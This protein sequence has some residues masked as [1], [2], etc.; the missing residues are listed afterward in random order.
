MQVDGRVGTVEYFRRKPLSG[1]DREDDVRI[2]RD[3]RELTERV[4]SGERPPPGKRIAA[5]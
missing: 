2:V 5:G 1:D 4:T 3:G